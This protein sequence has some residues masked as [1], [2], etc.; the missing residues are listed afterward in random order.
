MLNRIIASSDGNDT[1][2]IYCREEKQRKVL[3]RSQSILAEGETLEQLKQAFG[4][5]NVKVV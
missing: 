4:A 2:T 1:V 5:D 3:T